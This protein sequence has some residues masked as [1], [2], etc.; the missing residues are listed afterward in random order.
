MP[1]GLILKG[2][3]PKSLTPTAAVKNSSKTYNKSYLPA[4]CGEAE[5]R[6][7]I[8]VPHIKHDYSNNNSLQKRVKLKNM[9][10][11]VLYV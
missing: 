11:R 5:K 2:I 6:T 3:T 4:V 8:F 7:T 1:K 10:G 9:Q